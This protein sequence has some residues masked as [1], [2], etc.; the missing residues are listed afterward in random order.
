MIR[1]QEWA[2]KN[3][4]QIFLFVCLATLSLGCCKAFSLAVVSGS[5]YSAA[6]RRLLI[7]EAFLAVKFGL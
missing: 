1:Y 4:D 2:V 6:G 5:Y 3:F 7:A